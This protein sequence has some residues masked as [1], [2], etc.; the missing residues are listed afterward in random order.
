M[1]IHYE[2]RTLRIKINRILSKFIRIINVQRFIM[3][4]ESIFIKYLN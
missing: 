2:I 4:V 3:R 1:V